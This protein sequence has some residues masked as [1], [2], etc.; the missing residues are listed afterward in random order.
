MKSWQERFDEFVT[1]KQQ[2]AEG[3]TLPPY[4]T[5]VEHRDAGLLA[6]GNAWSS[7]AVRRRLLRLAPARSD[8]CGL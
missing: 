6:V 3:A 7:A 5:E 4:I 8:P 2:E 1:R